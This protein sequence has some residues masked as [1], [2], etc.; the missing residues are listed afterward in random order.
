MKLPGVVELR[1][2]SVRDTSIDKVGTG[3][4][5]A[6]I[7]VRSLLHANWSTAGIV[8]GFSESIVGHLI[9][10]GANK[11]SIITIEGCSRISIRELVRQT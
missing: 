5:V 11:R 1:D 4:R 9:H 10:I 8:H 3:Y 2:A 6:A 7:V